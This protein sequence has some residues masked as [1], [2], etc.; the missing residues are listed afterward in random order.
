V[1]FHGELYARGRTRDDRPA[2][3][4]SNRFER[5]PGVRASRIGLKGEVRST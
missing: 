1:T 5:K 4:N 2:P 3:F